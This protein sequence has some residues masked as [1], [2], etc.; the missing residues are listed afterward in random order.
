M[1]DLNH[2]VDLDCRKSGSCQDENDVKFLFSKIF[3]G[4]HHAIVLECGGDSNNQ[5]KIAVSFPQSSADSHGPVLRVFATSNDIL[6]RALRHPS[7]HRFVT[8]L[9]AAVLAVPEAR[10]FQ[11]LARDRSL[12]KASPSSKRRAHARCESIGHPVAISHH[13]EKKIGRSVC[14]PVEVQSQSNGE[15]FLLQVGVRSSES[16][17]NGNFGA[18]GLSKSPNA[19]VPHF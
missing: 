9:H 3:T 19:V 2:Y 8:G 16:N 18:Y 6:D 13:H 10:A 1:S 5:R 17:G 11:I 12:D 4:I 7:V 14:F 15:R